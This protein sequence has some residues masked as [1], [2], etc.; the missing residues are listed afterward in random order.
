[1]LTRLEEVI[2]QMEKYKGIP[3]EVLIKS[4]EDA[5][6]EATKFRY[7]QDVAV[8]AKYNQVNGKVDIYLIKHVVE[9]VTNHNRE[10]SLH[11]A[12]S[13]N[14]SV[15]LGDILKVEV[16]K[17]ELG[18]TSATIAR[19]SIIKRIEAYK[20]N[21]P[22][23]DSLDID[24]QPLIQ[25]DSTITDSYTNEDQQI[26][27]PEKIEGSA[28]PV[29]NSHTTD[30]HIKTIRQF[31]NEQVQ[32][33][34]NL[35]KQQ[36]HEII[37]G[38]TNLLSSIEKEH[39]HLLLQ[40]AQIYDNSG[41]AQKADEYILKAIWHHIQDG[42]F[43]KETP[44]ELAILLSK[45]SA[46]WKPRLLS[47]KK[48][49]VEFIYESDLAVHNL[50]KV[51]HL[52]TIRKNL[53][54]LSEEI[55]NICITDPL[56]L[57]ELSLKVDSIC[58][59]LDE[60]YS[61][62]VEFP[63]PFD[64]INNNCISP[65]SN[66]NKKLPKNNQ[67]ELIEKLLQ[68]SDRLLKYSLK[69]SKRFMNLFDRIEY[70]RLHKSLWSGYN[71]KECIKEA[72]HLGEKIHT[73]LSSYKEYSDQRKLKTFLGRLGEICRNMVEFNVCES[74]SRKKR[75]HLLLRSIDLLQKSI[76]RGSKPVI[77][78][79]GRNYSRTGR[80]YMD[81]GQWDDAI[82]YFM[83]IKDIDS[84]KKVDKK[85]AFEARV[86][87]ADCY[88]NISLEAKKYGDIDGVSQCFKLAEE[89]YNKA[90][91]LLKL[92]PDDGRHL[93][94]KMANFYYHTQQYEKALPLYREIMN[95]ELDAS[96][97]EKKLY[98]C[99]SYR[100]GLCLV[101]MKKIPEAIQRFEITLQR[102][103]I[104]EYRLKPLLWLRGLLIHVKDFNRLNEIENQ[105]LNDNE[106]REL[107][108]IS[109]ER[110]RILLTP[111]MMEEYISQIGDRLSR[112]EHWAV[113]D[114]LKEM[115]NLNRL[116]EGH[117]DPVLMT[118]IAEA[119]SRI[120]DYESALKTLYYVKDLDRR[121][122]NQA[123]ALSYIGRVCIEQGK[124]QEAINVFQES[125]Q[126]GGDIGMLSL[127][128]TVYRKLKEYDLSIRKYEQILQSGKD[129][130]PYITKTGLAKTYWDKYQHEGKK[131]DIENAVSHLKDVINEYPENWQSC[132]LLARMSK[133]NDTTVL[134][135]LDT[136]IM[137]SPIADSR[138]FLIELITEDLFP[139]KAIAACLK[140][141]SS[142]KPTDTDYWP[143]VQSS[144]DF[145]MRTTIYSYFFSSADYFDKTLR[146][147]LSGI[148]NLHDWKNVLREYLCAE[149]GAYPDF[150][151]E[152]YAAQIK[153]ILYPLSKADINLNLILDNIIQSVYGFIQS[154]IPQDI[155]V[156][157][158]GLETK[159]VNLADM[160]ANGFKEAQIQAEGHTYILKHSNGIQPSMEI[161]YPTWHMF[162]KL[163]EWFY[164]LYDKGWA[165]ECAWN[166]IFSDSTEV[167][168][169]LET[170]KDD[171]VKCY[172][173]VKL[174]YNDENMESFK[175]AF[176]LTKSKHSICPIPQL[177]WFQYTFSESLNEEE[178][179][180]M[181]SV[182]I[183]M[184]SCIKLKDN[185]QQFS[186]FLDYMTSS[187]KD[188]LCGIFKPERYRKK[189][190]ELFP[191]DISMNLEGWM[192]FVHIYL[193]SHFGVL[194]TEIGIRDDQYRKVVHDDIKGPLGWISGASGQEEII[195]FLRNV[196]RL[197][198]ELGRVRRRRLESI[199][200]KSSIRRLN[201]ENILEQLIGELQ[202]KN[203]KINFEFLT[204]RCK[205][206]EGVEP[207]LKRAFMNLYTNAIFAANA[208]ERLKIATFIFEE[209]DYCVIRI[210]NP[211][212]E[213]MPPAPFST[214]I[215]L[216]SARFIIENEHHGE[217]KTDG[218]SQQGV[219]TSEV[220][221][222]FNI[223]K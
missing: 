56:D 101:Q 144:S 5:L 100:W 44:R 53:K 197:P 163:V 123:Q 106:I 107:Y 138:N 41:D 151:E 21:I 73:D 168:V 122:K 161:P 159:G 48:R 193:D 55:G 30:S 65:I 34:K 135:L 153:T 16:A 196:E 46:E 85:I 141:L 25:I 105:I 202:E 32:R 6:V 207:L 36:Q 189:A 156:L 18:K 77:E 188:G 3:H 121:P 183:E 72:Y 160:L 98:D 129:K 66:L 31:V 61:I 205:L 218:N 198:W 139:D 143:F 89:F 200:T 185:F 118:K 220:R 103:P 54:L 132:N 52:V 111:E 125:F 221:L 177:P 108:N 120:G 109:Q 133:S 222:P 78:Y 84:T 217:L 223:H 119:D 126:L 169:N 50:E 83:K 69:D 216:K 158:K 62:D 13:F 136:L 219:F 140:R 213:P 24:I 71:F 172:F 128:A 64:D 7:G 102:N 152:V 171:K 38:L 90:N 142:I 203:D 209:G 37:H 59:H 67:I 87:I 51:E 114:E 181:L 68:I 162:E 80:N 182:K 43:D 39:T 95:R 146:N 33:C 63:V 117:D 155:K 99:F 137:E 116:F 57:D 2:C 8:E 131:E 176:D 124:Y 49:C 170:H 191:A 195:D 42:S 76:L 93:K 75:R 149:K 215:G 70:L 175:V 167:M 17:E 148:L 11:E 187:F 199:T 201:M 4:L 145:L 58:K 166:D 211:F 104:K 134:D 127:Q 47:L 97:D 147:I 81:L 110:L 10:V 79:F 179:H 130:R 27:R 212:K 194:F 86:N 173:I 115:I 12:L 206:L 186:P 96:P 45:S 94:G 35:D 91:E 40:L 26:N 88:L 174:A 74:A 210:Q 192:D 23:K 184:P 180:G 1:M 190:I 9:R 165:S 15:K 150:F 28:K 20:E 164:P 113:I 154:E 208:L 178:K 60:T 14:K 157:Y 204:S 29:Y 214:Q 112:G 82:D 22:S 92:S 19:D